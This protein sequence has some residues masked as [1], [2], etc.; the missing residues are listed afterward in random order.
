[1]D[2]TTQPCTVLHRIAI[3]V[4]ITILNSVIT[5]VTTVMIYC[6][7]LQY[8][9][10]LSTAFHSLIPPLVPPLT[11]ALLLRFRSVN[12]TVGPGSSEWFAVDK[13]HCERIRRL[14]LHMHSVDILGKEGCW[15]ISP[16]FLAQHGI[17]FM[18]GKLPNLSYPILSQSYSVLTLSLHSIIPAPS[19]ER[20]WVIPHYLSVKIPLIEVTQICWNQGS[21]DRMM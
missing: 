10:L 8:T 3:I 7:A 13:R 6:T 14:V 18:H 5:V 11:L 12:C 15:F 19:E 17:P 20:S 4:T 9:T 21:R 16:Q 1:M 2:C